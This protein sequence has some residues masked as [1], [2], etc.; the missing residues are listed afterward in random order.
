MKAISYPNCR[1]HA[2]KPC[3]R[4]WR[5]SGGLSPA[6][7]AEPWVR[8]W[9]TSCWICGEKWHWNRF[10]SQFFCFSLS[11]SFHQ[12]PVLAY[13]HIIQG[14]TTGPLVSVIRSRS[15]TPSTWTWTPKDINLL[16]NI[17]NNSGTVNL[18]SSVKVTRIQRNV[19]FKN[20]AILFFPKMYQ[21]ISFTRL[22]LYVRSKNKKSG[23]RIITIEY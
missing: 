23:N 11:V 2:I 18:T 1:K 13:H 17:D 8:G 16:I 10:S 9:A 14:W 6:S 21:L 12:L 5:G 19:W 22:R 15:L 7:H 20:R 4:P 3:I